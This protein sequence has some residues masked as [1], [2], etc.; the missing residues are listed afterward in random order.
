[1]FDTTSF[2]RFNTLVVVVFGTN[3][4]SSLR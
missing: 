4:G 3:F 1:M 2:I